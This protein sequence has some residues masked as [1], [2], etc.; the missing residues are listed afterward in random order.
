VNDL[1]AELTA[2]PEALEALLVATARPLSPHDLVQHWLGLAEGAAQMARLA[3][4]GGDAP[5]GLSWTRCAVAIYDALTDDVVGWNSFDIS[6]MSARVQAIGAIGSH[7]GDTVLDPEVVIRWV[8]SALTRSV[9]E[10]LNQSARFREALA[11]GAKPSLD[12]GRKLRCIKNR[13]GVLQELDVV[14]PVPADLRP[15]LQVRDQ[16]V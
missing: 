15:W 7:H 11:S 8:R 6:G 12:D 9:D 14:V 16:L 10:A 3:F 2:G 13:L 1:E 5:V 4:E